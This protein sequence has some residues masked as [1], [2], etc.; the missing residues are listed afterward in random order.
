M[1]SVKPGVSSEEA[2]ERLKALI[3]M[4]NKQRMIEE[5]MGKIR[6]KIGIISGK[7][8]VG[9][10]T[11]TT[12]LSLALASRGYRIGIIDSDFHGP[13]IPRM[14]GVEDRRVMVTRDRRMIPVGGP[15]GIKVMSI[16]FFLPDPTTAVIWR[17]PLKKSFLEEILASTQFGELDFLIVDLPPGTGDEA[18]NLIQAVPNLTGLIAVTQPTDVSGLAVAKSIDFALKANVRVLGVIEN[19]SGFRCPGSDELFRVF[20]GNAGEELANMFNI[21]LLGR[22]PIEPWLAEAEDRGGL[23]VIDNPDSDFSREFNR[24]VDKLLGILG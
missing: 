3:E 19:M 13:T 21:P 8:G 16:F 9:K 14:L 11:V 4:H 6:F 12:S 7:G 18:L 15:M 5:N 20:P 23:Y 10:S 24:I 2:K 1:P 17:G 22:I